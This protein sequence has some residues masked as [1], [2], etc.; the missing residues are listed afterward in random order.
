MSLENQQRRLAYLKK[1]RPGDPEIAKLQ[2]AIKKAGGGT[3]NPDGTT[4]KNGGSQESIDAFLD[5]MFDNFKPI[6]FSGAPS[7]LGADDLEAA[8]LEEEN[9][10]Y[11]QE[12]K[13]LERNRTRDLEEMKQEMANRGIAYDPA[14]P[15][16][17]YG[18]SVGS[19]TEKYDDASQDA[20][21][22]ARINS[23]QLM[24]AKAAT[25]KTAYD[26][27]I[28]T[29]TKS[30]NSQLDGINAGSG[31]LSV[32]MQKYGIDREEAQRILDRK[33]AERIAKM[34]IGARNRGGGGGGGASS[35]GGFQIM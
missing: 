4:N 33:S 14:N 5:S 1:N 32:L 22:R 31:A 30:Y 10:I 12:T 19:V 6:D 27:F 25:N 28:E 23:T 35:G 16:S 7:I 24:S 20:R 9:I 17:L 26:S 8:R 3:T 34:E 11:G 29:A 18:K 15:E 2:A 21:D 13:D